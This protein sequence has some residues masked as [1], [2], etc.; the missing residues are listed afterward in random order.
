MRTSK[1]KNH[2]R[3]KSMVMKRSKGKKT[4]KRAKTQP[5]KHSKTNS[6][7]N[8]KKNRKHKQSGGNLYG[9]DNFNSETKVRPMPKPPGFDVQCT[10]L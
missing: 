6:K 1:Q 9:I 10:I 4:S 3:S 2:Y 8:K 5:T 7:N